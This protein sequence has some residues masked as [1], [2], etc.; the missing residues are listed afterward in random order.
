MCSRRS[1]RASGACSNG[2]ASET[3]TR[4][5]SAADEW[6]EDAAVLAGMAGASVQGTFALGPR[7]GKRARPCG[8]VP[9]EDTVP[10]PGRCHARQEGFRPRGR[11][12]G[13]GR[14]AG[15]ARAALPVRAA[16]NRRAGPAP[17]DRRGAGPAAAPAPVVGWH[18]APPVGSP[19]TAGAAGRPA[20]S[21][22]LRAPRAESRG[23]PAAPHQP[24]SVSWRTRATGGVALRPC[25]GPSRATSRDGGRSSWVSGTPPIAARPAP[26]TRPRPKSA[27]TPA[28]SAPP[29]HPR[30]ECASTPAR[31]E[32]P[33][34]RPIRPASGS[35]DRPAKRHGALR[36]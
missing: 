25:S 16:A 31:A 2:G 24:H 7:A 15:P 14:P 8:A 30:P 20:R 19:R 4:G 34:P 21:T 11:R 18:H 23:D 32:P 9:V 1:C 3:A 35:G 12:E 26:P 13:P 27:P 29:T 5:A 33:S 28:R 10:G 22:S 17:A 36:T 6:A